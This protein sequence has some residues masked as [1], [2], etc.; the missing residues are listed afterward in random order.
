M[1]LKA[2][3]QQDRFCWCNYNFKCHKT[4]QIRHLQAKQARKNVPPNVFTR[5]EVRTIVRC[6]FWRS[7]HSIKVNWDVFRGYKETSKVSFVYLKGKVQQKAMFNVFTM[8]DVFKVCFVYLDCKVDQDRLGLMHWRIK[9]LK[10]KELSN[11]K[12]KKTL[13]RYLWSFEILKPLRKCNNAVFR[14]C[15][16]KRKVQRTYLAFK[17]L[18]IKRR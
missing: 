17:N 9:N 2:K 11:S 12:K 4:T 13:V 15:K 8:F 6:M 7:N 18:K 5:F 1:F 14:V 3:L 16:E 10:M